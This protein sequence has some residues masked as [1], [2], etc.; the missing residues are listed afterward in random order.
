MTGLNASVLVRHLI[1]DDPAQS[2]KASKCILNECTRESPG[3]INRI[4]LCELVWVLETAYGYSRHEIAIALES[5]LRTSQFLIDNL[6]TAWSALRAYR[7]GNADFSDYLIAAA[8]RDLGCKRT[9]TFD[10][11]AGKA[12]EFE[13][14]L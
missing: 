8:N 4:V 2:R 10:K 5:I 9:V 12:E 6:S 3:A 13:L 7:T 11:T 1:G 14:L